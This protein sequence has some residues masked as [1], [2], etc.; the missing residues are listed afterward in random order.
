GD[1]LTGVIHAAGVVDDG[2]IGSLTPARVAAVMGPKADA[3]WHLHE[4]TRDVDLDSFVLFSS[5]AAAFGGAGQGSYVAANA[6]LDALAARGAEL[7]ALLRALA[8]RSGSQARRSASA[9]P[10]GGPADDTLRDQLAG[11]REDEQKRVLLDLVR[12]HV[13]AVLGHASPEAVEPGRAF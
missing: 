6:F 9:T 4:L 3:A 13:A 2:V 5:V 10:G 12:A 7:P 8:P 11:L 1:R